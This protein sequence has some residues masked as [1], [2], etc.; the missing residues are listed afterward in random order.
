MYLSGKFWALSF[1]Y[2]ISTNYYST[3]MSQ[4]N[5]EILNSQIWLAEIETEGSLDF[6]I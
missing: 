5:L 6:P 3:A 2:M 1:F 4:K